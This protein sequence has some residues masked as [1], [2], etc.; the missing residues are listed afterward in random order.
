LNTT[1]L[2]PR[3]FIVLLAGWLCFSGGK[4]SFIAASITKERGVYTTVAMPGRP[5]DMPASGYT[6][7][8]SFGLGQTPAAVVIGYGFQDGGNNYPLEFNLELTEIAT[9]KVLENLNG[10]AYAGKAAVFDLTI[11]KSGDY[12]LRLLV[13]GSVYDTWD[14]TVNREDATSG[15]TTANPRAFAHRD[16]SASLTGT[17]DALMDYDDYFLQ[18]INYYVLKA[19]EDADSSLFAQIPVGQMAIQFV[20]TDNGKVTAA[21]ITENTLNADLGK[22]FLHAF[23][24]GSPY[25]AWPAPAKAALGTNARPM[26]V[27][28][29][30]D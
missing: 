19:R 10:S 29:F 21:K 25:K 7:C 8:K 4:Q 18:A 24:S 26:T 22:F 20:Q 13:K 28:F 3:F 15:N 12:R 23:E 9:G 14:F 6:S 2:N 5:L 17:P 16:F 1:G 30:Y 11:H 27:T